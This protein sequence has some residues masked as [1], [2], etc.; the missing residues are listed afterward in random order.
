[1]HHRA[2]VADACIL[3]RRARASGQAFGS[4]SL[5][6]AERGHASRDDLDRFARVGVPVHRGVPSAEGAR[7]PRM[8]PLEIDA[9]GS[10]SS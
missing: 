8:P 1:M 10:S 6:I 7:S 9:S 3:R 4:V 5:E 2:S